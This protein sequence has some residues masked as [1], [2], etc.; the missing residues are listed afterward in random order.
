MY[1]RKYADRSFCLDYIDIARKWLSSPLCRNV[2][3]IQFEWSPFLLLS[4]AALLWPPCPCFDIIFGRRSREGVVSIW[5]CLLPMQERDNPYTC[6]ATVIYRELWFYC[7]RT[8]VAVVG[9]VP[10]RELAILFWLYC[11]Y[12]RTHCRCRWDCARWG[13]GWGSGRG[14]VYCRQIVNIFKTVVGGIAI[15]P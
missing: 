7:H 8:I 10:D 11:R 3:Q 13:W 15:V 2:S 14:G 1:F 12:C 9:F 5:R 6:I 4:M